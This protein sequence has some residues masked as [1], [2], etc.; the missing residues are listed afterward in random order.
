MNN[1]TTCKYYVQR[2][3]TSCNKNRLTALY[4]R[5][6]EHQPMFSPS[7]F[8]FFRHCVDLFL[9]FITIFR[10]LMVILAM[11]DKVRRVFF[12]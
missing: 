4:F 8:L 10:K 6:L 11:N 2:S 1:Q 7:H 3:T 12:F 5:D 9:D